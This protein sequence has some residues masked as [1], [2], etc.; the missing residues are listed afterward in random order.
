MAHEPHYPYLTHYSYSLI[1]ITQSIL[2]YLL[3]L[4]VGG[5]CV[6][7]RVAVALL[8]VIERIVDA[9]RDSGEERMKNEIESR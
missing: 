9:R 5:V 7:A 1:T 8:W 2:V 3:L 6:S 4:S